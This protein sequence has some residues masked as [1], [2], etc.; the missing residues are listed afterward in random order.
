MV[1]FN[2]LTGT[3]VHGEQSRVRKFGRVL[4]EHCLIDC[5]LL[6][7]NNNDVHSKR[8]HQTTYACAPADAARWNCWR[9]TMLRVV[10]VCS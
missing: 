9:V 7:C 4:T 8:L 3:I 6:C 10:C 1:T 5:K 2:D